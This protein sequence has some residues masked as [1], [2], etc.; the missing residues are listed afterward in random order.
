MTH[1]VEF[2]SLFEYNKAAASL[3]VLKVKSTGAGFTHFDY[4]EYQKKYHAIANHKQHQGSKHQYTSP[5]KLRAD[6]QTQITSGY[7]DK[8]TSG[9]KSSRL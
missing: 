5:V 1:V 2:V 4:D 8:R 9:S 6:K 7:L 3:R